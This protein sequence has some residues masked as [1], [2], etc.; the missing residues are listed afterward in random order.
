M[1][2]VFRP[3]LDWE[4]VAFE[5]EPVIRSGWLGMGP[6]VEELEKRLAEEV[7]AKHFIAMSSCTAA[8]Q[9]AV[10][11][12]DLPPGS[13]IL[14]TPISFVATA[15]AIVWAG[16][17][18]VFGA[19]DPLSGLLLA[20][21]YPGTV[22][23]IPVHLGGARCE[24]DSDDCP[25]IEDCAHAFGAPWLDAGQ[26]CLMRCWSFHAVKN[27]PMGDGG[28][29]STNNDALAERLRR[30]R[31]FGISKSTHARN[32]GGYTTEYDIAELG[33]KAQMNDIT[34]AIGLAAL[35]TY[36]QQVERRQII[37]SMY[38]AAFYDEHIAGTIE[39]PSYMPDDSACH[40]F[41]FFFRDREKVEAALKARGIGYSRH[42]RPI[43]S[44]D[45]FRKFAFLEGAASTESACYY[46][47]RA[48]VLPIYPDMTDADVQAVI[49]AVKAA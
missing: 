47:N 30:L 28:G 24:I 6:N 18:P 3:S 37:A 27:L 48:L 20:G 26:K 11:C 13:R 39:R 22:A 17:V 23:A 49:E 36:R 40:F 35:P 46:H 5:L 44:F 32:A 15:A 16:H 29:I 7:R 33:I 38:R 9:L 19:V 4:A 1:I 41:P 8:L 2:P 34:A 42:Y 21:D 14:T 45:P 10:H 25:I 43:W 31:W 12:L